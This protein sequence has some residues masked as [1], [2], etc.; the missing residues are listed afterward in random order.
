MSMVERCKHACHVTLLERVGGTLSDDLLEMVVRATMSEMRE[1]TKEMIEVGDT[2]SED[3]G[4]I[5][6]PS[7]GCDHG[8]PQCGRDVWRAMLDAALSEGS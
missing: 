2:V 4:D 8:G 1:P 3:A 6:D 5:W 7:G